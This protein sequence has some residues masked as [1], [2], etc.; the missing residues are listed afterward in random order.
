M[1]FNSPD[2]TPA[3]LELTEREMLIAKHAAK[4]AVREMQDDFYKMVGKGVVNRA[5]T[6]IGL[7][8]VLAAGW[9]YGSTQHISK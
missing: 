5:L 1:P 2:S 4:L 6:V 9:I 7:L 3:E 8:A